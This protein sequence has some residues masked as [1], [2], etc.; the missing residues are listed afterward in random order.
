[1]KLPVGI[2]MEALCSTTAMLEEE[3]V[4]MCLKALYTLL[5][6]PFPRKQLGQDPVLCRELLNVMHR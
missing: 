2:A 5:D 3:T 1:V 4:V 6:T